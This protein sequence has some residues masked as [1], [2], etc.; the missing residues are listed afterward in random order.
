MG[1]EG[2]SK[3]ICVRRFSPSPLSLFRFHLSL[4]P[5]KR[6]IL[7]LDDY[8]NDLP[9]LPRHYSAEYH[10]DSTKLFVSFDLHDSKQMIQEMKKVLLHVRDSRCGGNGLLLNPNKTIS[11]L[12]VFG[13]RQMTSKLHEFLLSLLGKDIIG[14]FS[15]R[16][17]RH[18]GSELNI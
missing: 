10:V 18:F 12:I 17:R 4:F 8:V 7:R 6:L 3:S 15:D 5:Q 16:P 1:V 14:A 13:S 9:E 2:S 11:K